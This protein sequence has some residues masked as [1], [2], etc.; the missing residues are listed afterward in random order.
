MRVSIIRLL[1]SLI[2]ILFVYILWL[3]FSDD[4]EDTTCYH[5]T[6]ELFRE[7]LH[8]LTFR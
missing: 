4:L 6:T 2:L 1:F 7:N 8:E 3:T 5:Y